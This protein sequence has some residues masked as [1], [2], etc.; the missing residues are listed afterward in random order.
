MP[1]DDRV[2][3]VEKALRAKLTPPPGIDILEPCKSLHP[4]FS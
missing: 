4:A 1:L 2:F 3:E